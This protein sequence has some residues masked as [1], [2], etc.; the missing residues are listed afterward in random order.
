VH[1]GQRST[2]VD[3]LPPI[4]DKVGP[5]TAATTQSPKLPVSGSTQNSADGGS[6][7]DVVFTDWWDNF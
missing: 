4:V 1:V 2:F 7:F 3:Q 5:S 6:L